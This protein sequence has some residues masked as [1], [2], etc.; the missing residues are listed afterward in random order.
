MEAASLRRKVRNLTV[1]SAPHDSLCFDIGALHRGS[2]DASDVRRNS[3]E[4]QQFV[5]VENERLTSI[6][7]VS[8]NQDAAGQ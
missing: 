4:V 5:K 1:Q 8:L 3:G 7:N 6:A 2:L